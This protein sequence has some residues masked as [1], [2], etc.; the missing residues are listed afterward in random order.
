VTGRLA[1]WAVLLVACG[2]VGGWWLAAAA[3]ALAAW[4]LVA[5][6]PPRHVLLAAVLLLA[7]VPIVWVLGNAGRLST[8]SPELVTGNPW[9]HRAAGTAL[10]LLL[11]GV[12]RDVRTEPASASAP[13][14]ASAGDAR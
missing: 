8:V 3:A 13:V 5:A 11:V 7:A 10:L 2:L 14:Q 9:P 4:H 12:V 1:R 6:P